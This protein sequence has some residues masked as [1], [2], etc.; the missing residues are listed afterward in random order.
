MSDALTI[1][2]IGE[3]ILDVLVAALDE[4]PS[5]DPDLLPSPPRYLQTPGLPVDDC[6][7]QI[8]VHVDPF[9]TIVSRDTRQVGW[10]YS[11]DFNITHGRC[12]PQ[13]TPVKGKALPVAPTA[14]AIAASAHQLNC[15]GWAMWNALHNAILRDGVLSPD[16]GKAAI[17]PLVARDPSGGCGGWVG[18]VTLT[19]DGYTPAPPGS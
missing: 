9:R 4:L 19:V 10:I 6:C 12:L 14:D 5:F 11:V 15:D 8:A 7:D 2:D 1:T 17:Q 3:T 16:C 18:A 13:P